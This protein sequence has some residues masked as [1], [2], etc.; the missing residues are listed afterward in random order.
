M[1]LHPARAARTDPTTPAFAFRLRYRPPDSHA[2]HRRIA[3]PPTNFG[4]RANHP[5]AQGKPTAPRSACA[6][7]RATPRGGRAGAMMDSAV[8]EHIFAP[9][10][11]PAADANDVAA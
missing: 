11:E 4:T 1:D 7:L 9:A 3:A 10:A 8:V 6:R 5:V 2:C